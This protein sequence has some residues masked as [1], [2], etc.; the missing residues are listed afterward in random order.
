MSCGAI[1]SWGFSPTD[2]RHRVEVF[3]GDA[4]ATVS[5]D[6]ARRLADRL[7]DSHLEI[8]PGA[9]HLLALPLWETLLATVA[10]PME[11]PVA[12]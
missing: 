5:P 7:P 1:Y 8:I 9:G 10:A 12:R 2:V 3:H 4:D 6:M 11:G